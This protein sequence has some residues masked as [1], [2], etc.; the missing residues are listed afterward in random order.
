MRAADLPN[1]YRLIGLASSVPSSKLLYAKALVSSAAIA[2]SIPN[3]PCR[4]ET[5]AKMSEIKPEPY[6]VPAVRQ[7]FE[8]FHESAG[9]AL[10]FL[11]NV[12][13]I[14]IHVKSASTGQ[15]E[16]LHK[17]SMRPEVC[18]VANNKSLPVV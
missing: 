15:V 2:N 10:L 6:T 1:I 9:Q 7:L 8:N 14:S 11:K 4:T 5:T 16:L 17:I 13:A 12:Q 3:C 18:L